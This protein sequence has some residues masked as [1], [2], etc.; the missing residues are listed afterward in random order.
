MYRELSISRKLMWMSM[1]A[2]GT[3]LLLA[4]SVYVVTDVWTFRNSMVDNFTA[5]A[6]IVALNGRSALLFHDSDSA[7]DTLS[8]LRV[9]PSV[10]A[11]GVYR[12][13]GTLFAAYRS[14]S[15]AG[16]ESLPDLLTDQSPH[17]DFSDGSLVLVRQIQVEGVPIGAV[18]LRSDLGELR[19]RLLLY[20]LVTVAVLIV[21]LL[22]ALALSSRLQR[23]IV[24]PIVNLT[25]AVHCITAERDYSVRVLVTGRD[26]VGH[27]AVAFNE[28]LEQIGA[29][30]AAI[31]V[32]EE[33]YRSLVSALTSVVWSADAD[34]RFGA[35]QSSWEAYTGQDWS[36]QQGIGW[37]AAFHPDDR[38][39]VQQAC[40]EAWSKGE[41]Y[42]A[43]GR[44]WHAARQEHRHVVIRGV[45]LLNSD[46]SIR[47][48]VGT[49]TDEH[50]RK[51]AEA[52]IV[53]LNAELEQRVNE[54]TA[55]LRI[56]N[57]ELEAFCYSVSHDLRAPLRS[58]EGFSQALVEDC[59]DT[60]GDQARGLI[61]RVQASTRRMAQ[62]IEDLLNL[63]RVTRADL[64]RE[65]VNLSEIARK[66]IAD[67]VLR[68][69]RV[70]VQVMVQDGVVARGDAR[71]L[72]AALENLLGNAWKFSGRNP[73]ARIG[74]GA[75]I[76]KG[77]TT[78]FVS[79]NGVGFDMAYA[80][81][82]FGAFQRLHGVK[83]FPGTGI[84]LA[85]VQRI[86]HRHGGRIWAE[87]EPGTGATFYFT[88]EGVSS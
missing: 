15:G 66:V 30:D 41:R 29:R 37:M 60:L 83:D 26:E 39:R 65:E 50:D 53:K 59:A 9:K 79:D 12:A 58:I 86:V 25:S 19:Q 24:G 80:D 11:A 88:L 55:E 5:Q 85:T 51:V 64:V 47:E 74:F 73:A 78:Y 67:L 84:G 32:S 21:S 18:Y 42:E 8:S 2:S 82:L 36:E 44:L 52:E 77:S 45:P 16:V 68:E 43:E 14:G 38:G 34:G 1:L 35:P 81:K 48:W 69:P 61:A 72:R 71:L 54:R 46:G 23:G 70:G 31:R 7:T 13:D 63:S 49:V 57:R 4:C 87:S 10:R 56:A 76:E 33:R 40:R 6:D 3:A 27:L 28:M 75:R 22:V 62:L 17:H 20:A